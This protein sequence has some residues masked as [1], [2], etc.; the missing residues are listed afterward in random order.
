MSVSFF[1]AGPDDRGRK[2]A[3]P[4]LWSSIFCLQVLIILGVASPFFP[5][6]LLFKNRSCFPGFPGWCGI[7]AWGPKFQLKGGARTR[8]PA[9][10]SLSYLLSV[11]EPAPKRQV[12][13]YWGTVDGQNRLP[14]RFVPELSARDLGRAKRRVHERFFPRIVPGSS[15]LFHTQRRRLVLLRQARSFAVVLERIAFLGSRSSLCFVVFPVWLFEASSQHLGSFRRSEA[16]GKDPLS[17]S[18]A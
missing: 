2:G 11:T 14:G 12:P 1:H 10:R 16:H 7:S 4:H 18:A 5:T 6:N 8:G 15:S 13:G 17:R 3:V 9:S